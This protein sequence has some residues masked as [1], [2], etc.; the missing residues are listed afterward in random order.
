M[1]REPLTDAE[2]VFYEASYAYVLARESGARHL[3]FYRKMS[4]AWRALVRAKEIRRDAA[5]RAA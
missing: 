4:K 3:P 1:K 5:R 2:Q